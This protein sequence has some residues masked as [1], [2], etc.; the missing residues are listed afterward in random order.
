M[1][2]D[3]RSIKVLTLNTI[4]FTICFACWTMNGVLVTWL[5]ERG[6]FAW[7]KVQ[8]GWLIGTPILTG[9]LLRLPLGVLTDKFGGRKVF[10]ILMLL[11]AIPM[12]LMSYADTYTHFLL[13]SLGFGVTGA[14]FAVGIAYTSVWFRKERQGTALGVFGVGNAGSALTS[15]AAPILLLSLSD[16]GQNLEAWRM[17]P[18]Y[19]AAALVAMT[20]VFYLFTAEKKAEHSKGFTLRQRLAPLKYARVWRFGLYYFVVFGGFVSLAQWL[21]PYYVNA[22]MM[23]I[24]MAGLMASIFSFPSGVIRALGGWMSDKYGARAVMY[25][26]FGTCLICFTLLFVPRMDIRSPGQGVMA[27]KA[28]TVTAVAGNIIETDNTSYELLP[29]PDNDPTLMEEG[30]LIL[31]SFSF[32]QEPVV[33]VGD[34]VIK[35]QLVARGVTHIYFQAN[36]WV[37]TVLVFIVGIMMGIGKA[38][39]YKFIPEYYPNDVGVVGGIVGVIGGLGGF[40]C[41]IIFG[42]LLRATG[43]WTTSWM[44]FFVVTLL[45]HVWMYVTVR[46]LMSAKAPVLSRQ[47]EESGQVGELEIPAHMLSQKKGKTE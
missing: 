32:W 10:S 9:S 11:A 42:Y 17:L 37:F 47:L 41:P 22:Y 24:A 46:K 18:R 20:V 16:A 45:C 6:V 30:T 36:V 8:I 38:A 33:K 25:W 28:G 43:I 40:V 5:V 2:E 34:Q 44:F 14:S 23:S 27:D 12:Y 26:V 39:V 7:D 3:S 15:I 1:T 35:K 4:A 19:Y 13:G 29:K 21:I 31:P